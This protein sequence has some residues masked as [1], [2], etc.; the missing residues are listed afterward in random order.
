MKKR[1]VFQR[2]NQIDIKYIQSLYHEVFKKKLSSKYYIWQYKHKKKFFSYIVKENNQIIGHVGFSIKSINFDDKIVNCAFRHTSMVANTFRNK[3]IY[4]QL[5][6]YASKQLKKENISFVLAWPN[7]L[8]LQSSNNH[9]NFN[10]MKSFKTYNLK[11]NFKKNVDTNFIKKRFSNINKIKKINF[12]QIENIYEKNNQ[13]FIIKNKSYLLKR[14]V[15]HPNSKNYFFYSFTDKDKF[16]LIIFRYYNDDLN[17]INIVEYFS[18]DLNFGIS[19]FIDYF[20]NHSCVIQVWNC[21]YN[22]LSHSFLKYLSFK[23][24]NPNFNIGF[25]PLCIKKDNNFYKLINNY[26]YSMGDTDVF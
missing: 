2:T 8:N 12:N 25:Y 13:W 6:S 9:K 26:N 24:S 21:R 18:N 10:F 14:Y 1:Y 17:Y 19:K 11:L 15:K 16:C 5:M 7:N 20:R 22:N 23:I 4:T 3:G